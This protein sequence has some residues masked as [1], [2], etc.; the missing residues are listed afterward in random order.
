[1]Y[2]IIQ[3]LTVIFLLDRNTDKE[4]AESPQICTLESYYETYK[5]FI[6]I[7]VGLLLLTSNVHTQG[8]F[9][10]GNVRNFLDEKHL[11]T[12]IN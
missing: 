6:K 7:C 8:G 5:K 1:M 3:C 2:R 4:I 12:T 11:D 10:D 9:F